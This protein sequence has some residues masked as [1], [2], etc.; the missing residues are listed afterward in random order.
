[1]TFGARIFVET[2][3]RRGDW[4]LKR[5][6]AWSALYAAL[7]VWAGVIVLLHR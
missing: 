4:P 1:M 7:F 6:L 5:K 2:I 3:R